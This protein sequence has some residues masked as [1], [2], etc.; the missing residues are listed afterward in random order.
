MINFLSW[1]ISLLSCNFHLLRCDICLEYSSIHLFH[2]NFFFHLLF[3]TFYDSAR[4]V[5]F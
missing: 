4:T 1:K 5:F 2:N 3:S